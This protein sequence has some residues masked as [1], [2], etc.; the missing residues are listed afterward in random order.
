M[1]GEDGAHGEGGTIEFPE[2]VEEGG[3]EIALLRRGGGKDFLSQLKERKKRP[4]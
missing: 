4:E 2:N 1:G 3:G